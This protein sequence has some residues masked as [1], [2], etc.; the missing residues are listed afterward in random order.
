MVR[1]YTGIFI[2]LL[3]TYVTLA[4]SLPTDPKVLSRYDF[5]QTEAR[6]LNITVIVPLVLIY[7]TA[8]YGFVRFYLYAASVRQSKEGP[9]LQ[10]LSKG[11]MALAFSLPVSSIVGSLS[12][13]IKHRQPALEAEAV[14]FRNY[15]TLLFAATALFLI[16]QGA[17]KL[18]DTL[19]K[20]N[21]STLPLVGF[22]GAILLAS[23]YTWLIMTRDR[24]VSG[25]EAYFLPDWLL[26]VTFVVPLT[27]AW[28]LGI[29]AAFQLYDYQRSVKGSLYR[30]ALQYVSVG[31]GVLIGVSVL[32]QWLT[33]MTEQ[34][35]RLNLTP[36]LALVYF[37]VL[38]YAGGYGLLARGAKKLKQFEEA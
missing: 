12:G 20:R 4:F 24:G 19:K 10:Q 9:G 34:L 31:I 11:L 30:R 14:I 23:V 35:N 26:L 16:A 17:Q 29:R 32:I 37:L 27:I 7:L 28:S 13:Y 25:T 38:L 22:S 21:G 6:L 18:Y 33:T 5:S 3:A 15:V 2:A 36:L 1:K 8:L